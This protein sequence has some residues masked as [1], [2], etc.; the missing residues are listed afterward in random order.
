M[1]TIKCECWCCG[2]S[3]PAT[4]RDDAGLDVCDECRDYATDDDGTVVCARDDRYVDAGFW[5]GGGSEGVV[6]T[7]WVS[8]PTVRPRAV[9]A[10]SKPRV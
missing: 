4:T 3:E 2:C 1:T 10:V 7:G 9:A 6:G 5:T 8:R